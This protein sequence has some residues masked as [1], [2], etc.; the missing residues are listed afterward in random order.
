MA[1][2]D[3]NLPLLPVG[4]EGQPGV[5]GEGLHGA[6]PRACPGA[7]GR[8]S[9][10]PGT[11]PPHCGNASGRRAVRALAHPQAGLRIALEDVALGARE[12]RRIHPMRRSVWR[13]WPT[14]S[15]TGVAVIAR[16]RTASPAS[17]TPSRDA[18]RLPLS[19]PRLLWASSMITRSNTPGP[20]R[21]PAPA[22]AAALVAPVVA[23]SRAASQSVRATRS[24][25]QAGGGF[26]P[27]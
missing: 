3:G 4:M 20:A 22:R 13:H 6:H 9:V 27:C 26:S 2:V 14:P 23:P 16:C 19:L 7:A 11:L 21:R 1:G 5:R 12:R 24:A 15:S 17:T 25:E 18:R 8:A 10:P